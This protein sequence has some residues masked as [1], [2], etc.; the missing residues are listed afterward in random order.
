[1]ICH[2]NGFNFHFLMIPGLE[3]LFIYLLIICMCYFVKYPGLLPILKSGYCSLLLSCLTPWYIL[4]INSLSDMWFANILSNSIC[5]FLALWSIFFIVQKVLVLCNLYCLSFAFLSCALCV[6]S[7][8]S[9]RAMSWSLSLYV[10]FQK[11]YNLGSYTWVFNLFW[12]LLYIC[13]NI[14]V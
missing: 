4:N 12:I 11:F 8:N 9:A 5:G 10:F 7:K 13:W 6:T 1:M 3:P 14:K 2:W